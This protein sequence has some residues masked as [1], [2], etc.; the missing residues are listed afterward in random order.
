[1][2]WFLRSLLPTIRKDVSLNFPQIEEV[3]LQIVLKYD[4]IYT[5][6]GYVYTVLPDLPS[7][8]GANAPGESYATDD[9]IGALSHPYTHPPMGY[10]FP[11]GGANSSS[12]FTPPGS[13]YP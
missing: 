7:P 13:M 6:F 3:T 1:M 9:I 4:L 8:D 12:T 10:G 2:D 11:Q 5:Q